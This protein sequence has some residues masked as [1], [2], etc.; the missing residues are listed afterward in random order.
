MTA[1]QTYTPLE[2]NPENVQ[3]IK[4]GYNDTGLRDTSSIA[5][6]ILWYQTVNHNTTPRLKQHSFR[7]TQ[8]IQSLLWCHNQVCVFPP[9]GIYHLNSVIILASCG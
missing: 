2:D 4:P 1:W 5:S 3:I 7:A 8:I 6:D 9:S